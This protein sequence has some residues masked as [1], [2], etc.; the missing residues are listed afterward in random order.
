MKPSPHEESRRWLEQARA[1]A[2]VATDNLGLGHHFHV[3]YVSQQVAEKALKAHLYGQ[4]E[5]LVYGHSVDELCGWAGRYDPEFLK[6]RDDLKVLDT[7]YI[8]TRYPNGLAPGAIP[9]RAFGRRQA[10]EA[11]ALAERVV[12]LVSAKLNL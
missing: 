4:G 10:E 8:A 9:A 11:V 7:Y 12:A 1:E 5:E 2:K 3:C 6:A